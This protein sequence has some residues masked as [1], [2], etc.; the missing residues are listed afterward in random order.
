VEPI[1]QAEPSPFTGK[2]IFL[3]EIIL[4]S[5]I[6]NQLELL[7]YTEQQNRRSFAIERE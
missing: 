4:N 5:T 2:Q 6:R 1:R 3:I 7:A